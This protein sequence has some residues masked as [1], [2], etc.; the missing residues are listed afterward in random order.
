ALCGRP[1]EEGILLVLQGGQRNDR[2][3]YYR[4]RD[5]SYCKRFYCSRCSSHLIGRG[6]CMT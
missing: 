6:V 3:T 5:A 1:V 2:C 4:C